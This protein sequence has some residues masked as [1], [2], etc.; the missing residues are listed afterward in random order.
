MG[1]G[2]P[3]QSRACTFD[4]A[5][6]RGPRGLPRGTQRCSVGLPLARTKQ[7]RGSP[8]RFRGSR[9]DPVA[10][11]QRLSRQHRVSVP[12][13]TYCIV[14]PSG[15][16]RGDGA[17]H[18]HSGLRCAAQPRARAPAADAAEP[19]SPFVL[20]GH[21][22]ADQRED[23]RP[24]RCVVPPTRPSVRV[25]RSPLR[26]ETGAPWVRIELGSEGVSIRW[27]GGSATAE[28]R[29]G[30]EDVFRPQASGL[31]ACKDEGRRT[32]SVG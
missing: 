9:A 2:A 1:C 19:L 29:M 32:G 24:E 30:R 18:S 28:E 22:S 5:G 6:G 8:A 31:Q 21:G 27:M 20:A 3:A 16:E 14:T 12:I 4:A 17:P 7:H 25:R 13:H 26:R 11:V 15:L 10:T 23:H